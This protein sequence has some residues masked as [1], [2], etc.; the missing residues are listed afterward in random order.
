MFTL[1]SIIVATYV[2]F[3]VALGR[4]LHLASTDDIARERIRAASAHAVPAWR[5]AATPGPVCPSTSTR[6]PG[7]S[8]LS[9][10]L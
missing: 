10:F 1:I 5:Q 4:F 2:L 3:T 9:S 8:R 6:T 7:G